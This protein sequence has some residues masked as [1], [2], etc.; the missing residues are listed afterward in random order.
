MNIKEIIKSQMLYDSTEDKFYDVHK[1]KI[2]S[3]EIFEFKINELINEND[4]AKTF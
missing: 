1:L 4:F 2:S 3:E